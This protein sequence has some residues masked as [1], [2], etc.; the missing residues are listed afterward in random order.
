MSAKDNQL[1]SQRC[2]LCCNAHCMC[3]KRYQHSLCIL[4]T[5]YVKLYIRYIQY[6]VHPR[7]K[8]EK[9]SLLPSKVL[10][11]LLYSVNYTFYLMSNSHSLKSLVYYALNQAKCF[12]EAVLSLR[13]D[14]FTIHCCIPH[15]CPC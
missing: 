7:S 2:T 13:G 14:S 11:L 8:V 5:M 4:N 9:F 12:T 3:I 15:V 10:I 1:I 6:I